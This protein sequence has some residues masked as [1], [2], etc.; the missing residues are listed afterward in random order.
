[1]TKECI[2]KNKERELIDSAQIHRK[3][4]CQKPKEEANATELN[5]AK[6]L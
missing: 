1:M 4:S 2:P 5:V 3:G 6:M